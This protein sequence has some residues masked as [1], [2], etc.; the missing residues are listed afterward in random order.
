MSEKIFTYENL[1]KY[2]TDSSS[3]SSVKELNDTYNFGEPIMNFFVCTCF[4]YLLV[5]ECV[6]RPK[7]FLSFH[8]HQ[9]G[10]N[11][12]IIVR[13]TYQCTVLLQR[14]Q[15]N[16]GEPKLLRSIDWEKKK[17]QLHCS[18]VVVYCLLKS[19]SVY[20]LNFQDPVTSN[21]HLN[22]AREMNMMADTFFTTLWA[23]KHYMWNCCL[24]R[25]NLS[26]LFH[27]YY[28]GLLI[29]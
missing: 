4:T 19:D 23:K 27:V 15:L 25:L 9:S 20:L 2:S 17:P 14:Q 29:Q 16:W 24:F 22:L 1:Y 18:A 3:T 11:R 13:T 5:T 28:Y 12:C 10:S 6:K 8:C 26:W 7:K 21:W